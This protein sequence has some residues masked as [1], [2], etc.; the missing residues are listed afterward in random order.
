MFAI[1]FAGWLG[2]GDQIL[3]RFDQVNTVD[4][5]DQTDNRLKHWRETW[6]A[7]QEFGI[8]G[9]GVGAYGEVHR[10][11]RVDSETSIYRYGESQ[12]FQTLVELGWPGLAV[13][14]IAWYLMAY[15]STFL[16]WQGSSATSIA[17]GVAGVFT[18]VSVFVAS[19][20][21]F[22]LY[23]PANLLLMSLFC[24]FVAFHAQSLATRLKKKNWLKLETHNTIAQILLLVLFA[25]LAMY[26]LDFYRKW[27]IE[28]AVQEYPFRTFAVNNPTLD[29]TNRL[30]EKISP[31]VETTQNREGLNY[32]ARL[33]IHRSRLQLY[34]DL[35][36][37]LADDLAKKQRWDRTALDM[38]HENAWS[39]REGGMLFSATKFLRREFIVDN[40]PWA[41]KYL[42]ASREVAPMEPGTHIRLAQINALIGTSK[43]ASEDIERAIKIAPTKTGLRLLAA[44]YYLQSR[45]G[46]AAV[47]QLHELL[48]IDPRQ[49]KNAMKLIFGGANRNVARI[50][51]MQVVNEI[52]PDDPKLLYS[53]ATNYLLPDTDSKIAALEKADGL[54]V[55]VSAADR[56]RI[57]LKA[58]VKMEKK[59]YSGA[60]EQYESLLDSNPSDYET[61]L[62]LAKLLMSLEDF[63]G[64]KSKLDYIYRMGGLPKRQKEIENL[65]E[66]AAKKVR[67]ARKAE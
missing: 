40:L 34:Q 11:Y 58:A 13:L 44:L 45:N 8:F 55:D 39:L 57:K 18:T 7:V 22:G 1:S 24:G 66:V 12:F 46:D 53:L 10:L 3:E 16:L 48:K 36:S 59:E 4:V 38:V 23:L 60:L 41:R 52:M 15:Y 54:L 43:S 2:F 6:P 33:Y 62:K 63:E 19:I 64:A 14:L 56:E 27:Q 31:L 35:E 28:S 30:I 61:L 20:F 26:S 21:D 50:D 29:E 9:S 25:S 67:E 49:F 47:E 32:M 37:V 5:T 65:R 17:V 51:E 42:M